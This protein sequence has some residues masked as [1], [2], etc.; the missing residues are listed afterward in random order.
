M[1]KEKEHHLEELSHKRFYDIAEEDPD[2]T[3]WNIVDDSAKKIG[4]VKDLL[5]DP[6]AE[7]VRYLITNLKDGMFE[8]N[9][10]ILIPVGRA[11]LN[12]NAHTVELPTVTRDQITALPDYTGPWDLTERDEKKVLDTFA[13]TRNKER[14]KFVYDRKT[15][16]DHEDFN[17][18]RFYL[19]K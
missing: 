1:A 5:F 13:G 14:G 15:F 6:E 8:V 11:R 10:R 9:R 3:H 18:N 4:E 12:K 2:I 7:K 17:E 19:T 16:Y